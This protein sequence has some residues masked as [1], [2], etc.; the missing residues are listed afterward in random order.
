MIKAICYL[1]GTACLLSANLPSPKPISVTGKLPSDFNTNKYEIG[2]VWLVDTP[3]GERVELGSNIHPS[4]NDKKFNLVVDMP[5]EDMLIELGTTQ[6]GIGFILVYED[7]NQNNVVEFDELRGGV[8]DYM[9][10][11]LN[12][13]ID[14][15]LESIGKTKDDMPLFREIRQGL[16]I[17]TI[18]PAAEHDF[19]VPFDNLIST[20]KKKVKVELIIENFEIPNIT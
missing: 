8:E 14:E 2:I 1:I 6:L 18:I 7:V 5:N 19:D 10:T 12:G 20:K 3:Q 17:S 16:S 15:G 11:Y 4:S 13:D 9:V